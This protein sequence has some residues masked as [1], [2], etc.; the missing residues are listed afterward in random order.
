MH[1][2]NADP[3]ILRSFQKASIVPNA[4]SCKKEP[5]MTVPSQPSALPFQVLNAFTDRPDGGNP[6]GVVFLPPSATPWTAL[7]TRT[8]AMLAQ[9]VAQPVT[10]FICPTGSGLDDAAEATFAT[11]WFTVEQELAICGHATLAAAQA[12]FAQRPALRTLRFESTAGRVLVARR[13]EDE[14]IEIALEAST[15]RA[16][17]GEEANVL[18]TAVTLAYGD[19]VGVNF[20]GRGEGGFERYVLVELDTSDLG[21]LKVDKQALVSLARPLVDEHTLRNTRLHQIVS[22]TSSPADPQIHDLRS[23]RA[24]STAKATLSKRMPSADPHIHYW[25]HIGPKRVG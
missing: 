5:N 9:N 17:V 3:P 8:L 19:N 4:L 14:R 21:G 6:A 7:P 11:R 12:V 16:M 1:L 13:A 10:A 22:S 20:M 18:R 23:S 25:D 15:L 24:C 2:P